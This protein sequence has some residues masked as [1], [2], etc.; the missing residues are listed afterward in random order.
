[1]RV[2]RFRRS[3]VIIIYLDHMS[4]SVCSETHGQ[5]SELSNSSFRYWR[6]DQ[7]DNYGGV[8]GCAVIEPNAQ[9]LWHD[10]PCTNKYPLVS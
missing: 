4:G 2:N 5:W 6:S 9:G 1:M 10:V 7:P 3:L 8:E